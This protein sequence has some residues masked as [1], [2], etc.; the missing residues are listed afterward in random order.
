MSGPPQTSKAAAVPAESGS[1]GAG[2]GE[3]IISIRT[4]DGKTTKITAKADWTIQRLKEEFGQFRGQD[5]TRINMH[6]KG[7]RLKDEN[8]VGFYKIDSGK[9]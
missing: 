7:K 8:T 5:F 1:S 6:Y 9:L 2:S 3:I 4:L